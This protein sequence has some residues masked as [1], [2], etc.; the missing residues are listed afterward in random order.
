ML[1]SLGV[2]CLQGLSEKPFPCLQQR[3]LLVCSC[4][5]HAHCLPFH[6]ISMLVPISFYIAEIVLG[7]LF[8]H[9]RGIVY[10]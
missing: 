4:R 8:L 2:N 6:L 9:K 10:R 3:E 5:N 7:L 1:R